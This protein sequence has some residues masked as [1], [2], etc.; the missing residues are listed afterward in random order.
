LQGTA[1]AAELSEHAATSGAAVRRHV[2]EATIP[3][4]AR[5]NIGSPWRPRDAHPSAR[6][7]SRAP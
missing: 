4:T 5:P 3:R 6:G 2:S 1:G 7:S